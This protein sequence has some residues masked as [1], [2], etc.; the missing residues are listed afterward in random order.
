MVSLWWSQSAL[1]DQIDKATSELLP[2]NQEDIAL[3]FTISDNIR[4]KRVNSKEAMRSLK[5][6]LQ[7]KNP[8]VQLAALSLTDT[9]VKNAGDA[10]VREIAS[11]EFM[12]TLTMILHS[13]DC[14]LDVKN[15]ILAVIQ[16]WAIAAKNNPSLN[17]LTDT[18]HLLQ[19]ERFQFPTLNEHVNALLLETAAPPEWTDS[20]V[21]ERCRTPFTFTNRKHH[22]RNCGGTFCQECS[23]KS[24]PLPHLA[25]DDHVRVCYGCY[26]KLKLSRVGRKEPILPPQL[27][28]IPKNAS[29]Q[30][31]K[32]TS[33]SVVVS[34]SEDKQFEEDLKRA[35]ELSKAEV[36]QHYAPSTT[37][38]V[39][40]TDL[41]ST[42]QHEMNGIKEEEEREDPE[43]AAAIA[44]SLRDMEDAQKIELE[45]YNQQSN[46]RRTN[47]EELSNTEMENIEL[48]AALMER[49][50]AT[51]VNNIGT[52][53]QI[54][55]LYTQIAT[56]QPKLVKNLDDAIQR[57]NRYS[58]LHE[59]LNNAV[60]AY[61][62]L[63]EQRVANSY[64]RVYSTPSQQP[65][66]VSQQPVYNNA[67]A[68]QQYPQPNPQSLMY[69]SMPP[70]IG[71]ITYPGQP[72]S[73]PFAASPR[74][75]TLSPTAP[76]HGNPLS[77]IQP[78]TAIPTQ[79]PTPS[80]DQLDQRHFPQTVSPVGDNHHVSYNYDNN[81]LGRWVT[82][83]VSQLMQPPAPQ[84]MNFAPAPTHI[85]QQQQQQQQQATTR[86]QV[87]EASLIEL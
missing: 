47:T 56:L 50:N 1:D 10:F 8:N 55:Q 44:A 51:A 85:P 52:D 20:D 67:V 34:E 33:T 70:S 13:S 63:L 71:E 9:C 6:R 35:I 15:K 31:Q 25:I 32:A 77:G 65:Y 84:H 86:P 74:P 80:A 83:H 12:E 60:R 40:D 2:N 54:N 17:Y 69:P 79:D 68:P 41:G 16:T 81:N 78:S 26:V 73:Q 66:G 4:S 57:H 23:S 36:E 18:Y 22:C 82:T 3:H 24:L 37:T 5:R 76:S 64:Q 42:T 59:K 43:L 45:Y 14:N 48:F 62:R 19:H 75:T 29:R 7:H 61:D 38:A 58:M 28:A 11:R 87:E 27:E 53:E 49:M 21:C 46:S 72:S 39:N 30:D